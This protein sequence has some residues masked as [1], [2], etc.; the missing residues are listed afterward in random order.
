MLLD[1]GIGAISWL[2]VSVN[3]CGGIHRQV[4]RIEKVEGSRKR[5]GVGGKQKGDSYLGNGLKDGELP[6]EISGQKFIGAA[7]DVMTKAPKGELALPMLA[8]DAGRAQT[9]SF[10]WLIGGLFL[11]GKKISANTAKGVFPL[12]CQ[13][14]WIMSCQLVVVVVMLPTISLRRA[15]RVIAAREVNGISRSH[16]LLSRKGTTMGRDDP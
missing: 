2:I 3:D 10:V 13:P 8:I 16:K 14:P 6:I 11:R 9:I 12:K 7:A 5:S 4:V 15:P 1:N